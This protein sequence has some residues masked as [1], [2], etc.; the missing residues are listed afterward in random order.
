[1]SDLSPIE[2][3]NAY[4]RRDWPEVFTKPGGAAQAFMI[5]GAAWFAIGA[6]YGIVAAISLV[7]PELFDNISWLV[8][9]RTRPIHVNTMIYGFVTSILIGCGLHYVPAL[10]R[11]RLWSESVAW[12]GFVF[13]H[14][15]VLSG[16]FTFS[17]G[18]S[19]GR[20]YA[21]YLWVFD[22]TLVLS[23][24]LLL[25]DLLVTIGQRRENVLYVSVWYFLGMFIWMCGVYPIGNVM[26]RPATGAMPGILDSVFLWFYGHNLPGLLLTPLALGAAY[27][28]LPRITRTPLYSHTLSLAGFWT[29][30]ALYS[31]IG[32]HHILQ[33]PIP[34]WLKVYSV[35][36][37]MA[38]VIPVSIVLVN[39]WLTARGRGG[40]LWRDPAGRFVLAGTVWYL[41]TCIQGP[42]QS[43]PSMQ[44]VTHFN[45][46]TIGHAHIA[47]FGF[48]GFI[49]LG[50]LWHILPLAC[51]RRVYS[52]KWVN[53][54]F[55]LLVIGLSGF[56]AVLTIA[57]LIQGG[58]W[59]NGEVVYR[60]LPE[61]AVYMALRAML[62]V[63]I[64][65][66][67]LLGLL[68]VIMTCLAG[69]RFDP[70]EELQEAET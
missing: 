53:L 47:V 4:G 32:G 26:W 24:V 21:E 60:V 44:K 29:L 28:V 8:F 55:G 14:V 39:L 18:Y 64:G 41:L 1:M 68:N 12:L 45:N 37:S 3:S 43:L 46:W 17:L 42:L 25:W 52:N 69:E 48:S 5:A 65:S 66:A 9:G 38:M 61:I 27:Y 22:L 35:V 7:S 23:I 58:A 13:W 19:Q 63:L 54:Q 2:A 56:F 57:G 33:A 6:I 59:Y 34:N 62:G 20:E 16:P 40:L 11:T 67:A 15:T 30:V 31:H 70:S 50:A 10:L 49:A 36:D 51:G